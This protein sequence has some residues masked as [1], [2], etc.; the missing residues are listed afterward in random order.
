MALRYNS[1][2]NHASKFLKQ[3]VKGPMEVMSMLSQWL[4]VVKFSMM[5]TLQTNSDIEEVKTSVG[6]A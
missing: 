3:G 2:D 1:P 6:L 4:P 5:S